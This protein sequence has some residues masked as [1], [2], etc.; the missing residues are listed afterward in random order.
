MLCQI[1]KEPCVIW[2][3]GLSG[4]GKST[5]ANRIWSIL[6]KERIPCV[7][8]D[9]DALRCGLNSDLGFSAADRAENI[10]RVREIAKFLVD[11]GVFVVASFVSPYRCDRDAARE[12]IGQDR[13]I[14]VYVDCPLH[15]CEARDVKGLYKKARAGEIKNF[16][17]ID[18]PYE[19]PE[20]PDVAVRTHEESVDG[21]VQS[22]FD[23]LDSK[24][25]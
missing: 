12:L 16:T 7:L 20:N 25:C 19:A 11:S 21:C 9:G 13:F 4:S 3:T 14:E 6:S 1:K 22:I 5:I 23:A 24:L 2:L 18:D 8:L 10:R 15:V 17:G